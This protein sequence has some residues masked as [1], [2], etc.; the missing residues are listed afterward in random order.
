MSHGTFFTFGFFAIANGVRQPVVKP[1]SPT[2]KASS[3]PSA[4]SSTW[5]NFYS[6][7]IQY[8]DAAAALPAQIRVYSPPGDLPL[9]EDTIAFMVAKVHIPDKGL[10]LLDAICMHPLPGNPQSSDYED[11]APDMLYPYVYGIGTSK[12]KAET[13][14]D[15]KSKGFTVLVEERVRD[16]QEKSSVFCVLDGISPRWVNVPPPSPNSLI[17]F[18]G[19]CS[20]IRADGKLTIALEMVSYNPSPAAP[21]SSPPLADPSPQ[22]PSVKRRKFVAF[23]PSSSPVAGP[24]K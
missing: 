4:S 24:S 5:Y 2:K 9:A 3:T 8:S 12:G 16:K 21:P 10:I 7:T 20:G 19:V 13:L 23:Q 14:A 11:G 17:S 22:T 1:V 18:L 6:T 15:G